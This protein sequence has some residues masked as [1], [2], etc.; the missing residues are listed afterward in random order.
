MSRTI[1]IKLTLTSWQHPISRVARRFRSSTLSLIIFSL[2]LSFHICGWP[3]LL[4]ISWKTTMVSYYDITEWLTAFVTPETWTTDRNLNWL[5]LLSREHKA[6]PFKSLAKSFT[7][8]GRTRPLPAKDGCIHI[9]PR[10]KNKHVPV[11][12][13]GRDSGNNCSLSWTVALDRSRRTKLCRRWNHWPSTHAPATISIFPSFRT[14]PYELR[15]VFNELA[16]AHRK[17]PG[18]VALK[19]GFY[20]ALHLFLLRRRLHFKTCSRRV[21]RCFGVAA[22]AATVAIR[23]AKVADRRNHPA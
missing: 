15:L 18:P 17:S 10:A 3:S 22:L 23:F 20:S 4:Y 19:P 9:A 13:Q 1:P 21:W 2:K 6:R 12:K 8:V 11:F 5:N 7:V 16:T 14:V